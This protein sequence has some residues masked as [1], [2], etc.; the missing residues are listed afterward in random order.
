MRRADGVGVLLVAGRLRLLVGI[1]VVHADHVVFQEGAAIG[2]A[3]LVGGVIQA[4][5]HVAEHGVAEIGAFLFDH[6]EHSVGE[7]LPARQMDRQ[8]H[9]ADLRSACGTAQHLL[10]GWREVLADADLA[11][12]TGAGIRATRRKL[13]SRWRSPAR[14][15]SIDIALTSSGCDGSR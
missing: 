10:L 7:P 3:A 13:R 12:Q 2:K 1:E 8:R 5:I 6:I 15:S 4:G 9:A 11:D 14:S